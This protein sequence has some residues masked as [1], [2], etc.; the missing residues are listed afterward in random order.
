MF[1]V[2][3]GILQ[4]GTNNALFAVFL[5][6]GVAFLI[7]FYLYIRSRERPERRRCCRPGCSRTAS[8]TSPSSPRTCSGSFSWACRSSSPSSSRSS[9]IQRDR[10]GGC[11]HRR[12]RRHPRLVLRCGA[13]RE[14]VPAADA[15]RGR[16][17]RHPGRDRT[18]ARPRPRLVEGGR[19]RPGLLLIGLGLARC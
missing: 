10:D 18:P 13:T 17:R 6:L 19:L 5:A 14:E 1:C 4:A 15:D 2:V 12:D 16:L 7:A 11:L 3:F 9:R 8:P